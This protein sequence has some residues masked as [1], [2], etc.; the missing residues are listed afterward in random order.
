MTRPPITHCSTAITAFDELKP[1]ERIPFEAL[2]T[3]RAA[4]SQ[5][6]HIAY[7]LH[8]ASIDATP[9]ALHVRL[10]RAAVH[11]NRARL[12]L[13]AAVAPVRRAAAQLHLLDIQK[14]KIL[15]LCGQ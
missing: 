7:L 3:N 4:P 12:A 6:G 13:L 1:I 5:L 10:D 2:G 11:A 15:A 9:V 14:R 8:G